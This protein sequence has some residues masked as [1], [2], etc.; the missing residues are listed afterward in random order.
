MILLRVVAM[1]C[2]TTSVLQ[3]VAVAARCSAL[4]K[5]TRGMP[6]ANT[7]DLYCML[8]QCVAVAVCC[9]TLQLQCVAACCRYPRAACSWQMDVMWLSAA[10]CYNRSVL[11]VCLNQIK[12]NSQQKCLPACPWLWFHPSVLCDVIHSRV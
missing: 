5:P 12:K 6:V 11:A 3:H 10:V 9:S 2:C 8:L 7:P 4:Q 1:Y